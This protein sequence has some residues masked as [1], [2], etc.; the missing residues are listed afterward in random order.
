MNYK[1]I[2]NYVL[3]TVIFLAFA[4]RL[5]RPEWFL[6]HIPESYKDE[7]SQILLGLAVIIFVFPTVITA[8]VKLRSNSSVARYIAIC[9]CLLI[10]FLRIYY[11]N[12]NFDDTSLKLL[13][14]SIFL[15]IIPEFRILLE[16]IKKIKKGDF[17]VLLGEI[18]KLEDK[19][20]VAEATIGTEGT[21]SN[22][23]YEDISSELKS[24]LIEMASDPR[25]SLMM[26][27]IEIEGKIRSLASMTDIED[28]K[29][30]GSVIQLLRIMTRQNIIPSEVMPIFQDFW[31]IRN[32]IIH[33]GYKLE[34]DN[35]YSLV[36]LG[37]RILRLIPSKIVHSE[38]SG[39]IIVKAPEK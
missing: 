1:K 33:E 8:F 5:F 37:L 36:D 18:S 31:K 16:R 19:T 2:W 28:V 14:I 24:K 13:L 9:L 26:L 23:I 29:R 21:K 6:F 35:L 39:S 20:S 10:I 15:L 32:K 3:S 22:I 38:I 25:G 4:V 17:E 7:V 11:P 34:N 12:M 27:A 30:P